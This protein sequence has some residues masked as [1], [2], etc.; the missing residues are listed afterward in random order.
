MPP[1]RLTHLKRFYAIIDVLGQKE[2]QLKVLSACTGKMN[3][4]TRGVY[5]FQEIGET[6]NHTGDGARIVRVGTHALNAASRTKLWNRLSQHKGQ[7]SGG[8]NHRGSIFRLLVGAAL[9]EKNKWCCPT[10]G[11]GGSASPEVRQSEEFLEKLV[12]AHICQM[13]FLYLRIDDD[14]G[15]E[16]Q[17]GFIERNS[18]AL[19][20]NFDRK[21]FDP[22][23]PNWLGNYCPREKVRNSGLWNQRHVDEEYNPKFLDRLEALVEEM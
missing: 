22:P 4:P 21:S 7:R 8:G 18:T 9:V 3:W 20:S 23:S 16:T 6:R 2:K 14:P 10:W 17:R 13:P 15:I 19:L 12:S 1:N 11:G 5:F